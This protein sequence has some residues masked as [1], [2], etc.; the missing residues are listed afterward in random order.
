LQQVAAKDPGAWDRLVKL[1]GPLVF[2]W[3]RK[4]GLTEHDAADVMQDVFASV[5]RSIAG[6]ET[7]RTGSFRSWLW[8]I[9]RN[10]LA[11]LFRRRAQDAQAVGGTAA[12]EQLANVAESLSDDPQ[13]HTDRSELH[14]L[15]RR[16][17]DL[18]RGEF[19]E[20]TWNIFWQVAVNER[21]TSDVAQE[22]G[23]TANSVRQT[24]S[25]V[26]RRL[27]QVLGDDDSA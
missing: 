8:T 6:F 21:S 27:R 19:E 4:Q 20:R 16:G 18:V 10:Q 12:W 9:T 11:T 13:E 5:A 15:H 25:R 3:A 2:H 7:R 1:Y 23:I 14:S 26:L 22:F 17:L 24:K